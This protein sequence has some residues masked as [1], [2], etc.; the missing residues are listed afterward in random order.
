MHG[1]NCVHRDI[2]P[3]NILVNCAGIVKIAD[4][5]VAKAMDINFEMNKEASFV[6]TMCYMVSLTWFWT[7]DLCT[8]MLIYF[9]YLLNYQA[10]ERMMSKTYGVA[11]DVW[12][13]G[14][15]LLAVV[16]GKYPLLKSQE[17]SNYWDLMKV[18][19]DQALPRLD[20]SF[21]HNLQHF[22]NSCLHKNPDERASVKE[23]L[24]FPLMEDLGLPAASQVGPYQKH[25]PLSAF[26][27]GQVT[28][29][30]ATVEGSNAMLVKFAHLETVLEKVEMKY[31]LMVA[32]WKRQGHQQGHPRSSAD[33][34]SSYRSISARSCSMK[35]PTGP[36]TRLPNFVSGLGEWKH[37]AAQ[38]HL[39]L[40][41]VLS[42]AS[43]IIN[44]KYFAK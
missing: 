2:K 33:D 9:F 32:L 13:F 30:D 25:G 19:C 14:L 3:G 40:D 29:H 28:G 27:E 18:I 41:M 35:T 17:K 21:S 11:A 22:L 4:F 26:T 5:G 36:V 24:R 6:G 39:P 37:L 1:Q 38:L 43:T 20:N 44:S 42:T 16:L 8:S 23:L 12:S 34:N 31:Q 15:T 7:C 10:P